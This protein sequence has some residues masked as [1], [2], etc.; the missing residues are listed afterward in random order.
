MLMEKF[1][2]VGHVHSIHVCRNR[3][4]GVLISY[5]YVNFHQR[6]DA[7]RA[8]ATL[9]CELP[10]GKPMR[11]MWSPR[12]FTMKKSGIENLFKHGSLFLRRTTQ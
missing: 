10:I 2:S 5:A 1:S 7:E 3:N 8:L 4:A 11:F 9:N 6:A 12:K